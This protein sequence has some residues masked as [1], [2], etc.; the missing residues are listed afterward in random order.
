MASSQDR[1]AAPGADSGRSPIVVAPDDFPDRYGVRE[2]DGLQVLVGREAPGIAVRIERDFAFTEAEARK[3]GERTILLDGAGAFGPLVD[4]NA[5]LY[6]LDHHQ[7][8]LRAF[9]LA[10]CEQA[11]LLV[12]KGLELD[13]GEWTI[14]CNEVDLDSLFALWVLLNYRR[15][16]NFSPAERDRVV[17]LLRLEGAIDANGFELAEFCGLTGDELGRRRAELDRLH[18]IEVEARRRGEWAT[19]DPKDFCRR[20]L[21]EIDRLAYLPADLVDESAVE[22]EYGHVDI[23]QGKVAVVCR[24]SAGIYEVEQRLRKIWGERLG[25]VALEKEPGHFTLRRSASLAGIDL[26][27]AYDRLNLLDP[28]V[29]GRPPAKK[30]GGSDEIGGSPRKSGSGLSPREIVKILKLAYKRPPPGEAGRQTL[31][32]AGY[33][34]LAGLLA[35][36]AVML[37]RFLGWGPAERGLAASFPALLA[38]AVLAAAAWVMTRR[39]SRGWTWL[40]G[41]RLPAGWRWWPAALVLALLAALG[42]WRPPLEDGG[43]GRLGLAL[44]ALALLALGLEM[45]FRGLAHGMLLNYAEIEQ[46]DGK[47]FVSRPNLAAA[48]IFS[49]FGTLALWQLS[50]LP[51]FGFGAIGDGLALWLLLLGAGIL[52]GILRERSL[53][54]WPAAA[55]W[56]LG[57][58][59]RLCYELLL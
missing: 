49:V 5:H 10:S 56:A 23:G 42:A 57:S 2:R 30:W 59:A 55:A 28:A 34:L 12:K 48:A 39:E 6:N 43:P 1:L 22:E 11:L 19:L 18:A 25:I 31:R 3:L 36:G 58:Q 51:L 37:Q 24:D 7:G 9:T 13:K 32:A 27:T 52:A 44:L 54:L 41:W 46:L 16:R 40:H 50:A 4:D 14:Y 35:A 33:C 21:R 8:C 15:V 53:S 29:D 17:P 20:M 38:G 45:L 47:I 26:K